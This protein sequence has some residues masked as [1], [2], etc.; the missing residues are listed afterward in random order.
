MTK[1]LA[2]YSLIIT[3]FCIIMCLFLNDGD[4]N[5]FIGGIIFI[6]VLYSLWEMTNELKTKEI[7]DKQKE[8]IKK[9]E[10]LRKEIREEIEN[11]NK[12]V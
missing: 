1:I 7:T 12:K 2:Y 5:A 3:A 6:P 10:L 11:D 9:E 8:E 4:E